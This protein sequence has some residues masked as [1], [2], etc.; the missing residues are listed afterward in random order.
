MYA[1]IWFQNFSLQA[2]LRTERFEANAAIVILRETVHRSII[3]QVNSIAARYGI[4]EGHT[5]SQA[6]A[7]CRQLQVRPIKPLAEK[8]AK[9]T[10][11]SCLYS[12]TPLI[13]ERAYDRYTIDLSGIPETQQRERIQ[14]LL[15]SLR[16]LGFFPQIG[17]AASPEWAHYAA[18]C[19]E[20]LL[21]VDNAHDFFKE[22]SIP[23]AVENE[24]MQ[25]ILKQW[26]IHTLGAFA[27]LPKQAV[28]KRLGMEGLA[29]WQ[30][31]YNPQQRILEIK[32]PP[33]EFEAKVEMEY[34][35]ETLEPLLFILNRLIEQLCL[36]LTCAFLQAK[37]MI[38]ELTMDDGD[39]YRRIFKLPEPTTRKEK[40]RQVIETHLENLQTSSAI[41]TV[42]LQVIPTE[43]SNRQ[44]QLFQHSVKDPWKF[45]STLHQLIGLVGSENVGT[46]RLRDVHLPDSFRMEPPAQILE[47]ATPP[48]MP[49][50]RTTSLR[51]QRFR[52]SL[53]AHVKVIHGKPVSIQSKLVSG[54]VQSRRGP[55]HLSGAWWDPHHWKRTEWDIGLEDGTLL[56]I[57][58][59]RDNWFVEGVYG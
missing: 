15:Q 40:L 8:S 4:K 30:S 57:V 56:Q 49:L 14:H 13:E 10:I 6:I 48:H 23:I 44:P 22:V 55:W 11:F 7:K 32:Q 47:K 39:R 54:A 58:F 46:P 12:T 36:Q 31:L 1:V 50:S 34:E 45:S 38:L 24:K 17:V 18:K 19:A 53:P 59:T 9:N 16:T 20:P 27:A 3:Y 26:G 2:V 42:Y 52:P 35:I 37:V 41:T 29:L 25:L 28:A 43:A 5:V 21:W 51:L 33:Q